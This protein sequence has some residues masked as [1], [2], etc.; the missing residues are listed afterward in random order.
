MYFFFRIFPYDQ[1]YCATL[2]FTGSNLFNQQMRAHAVEHGFTLNEY[3][4]RPIGSRGKAC[5]WMCDRFIA[6]RCF[7]VI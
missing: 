2:Y 6:N 3:C 7:H 4:I 1:Y 5:F